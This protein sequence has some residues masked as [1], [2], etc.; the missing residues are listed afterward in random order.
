MMS[1]LEKVGLLSILETMAQEAQNSADRHRQ[2]YDKTDGKSE[3]A[4]GQYNDNRYSS[5]VVLGL[6]KAITEI[7]R[8]PTDK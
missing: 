8:I 7:Q 6:Q 3:Y 5:G 1:R 4:Q 2:H